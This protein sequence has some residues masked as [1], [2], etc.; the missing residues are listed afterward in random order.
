M[1]E[2]SGLEPDANSVHTVVAEPL[3]RKSNSQCG[4]PMLFWDNAAELPELTE[5]MRERHGDTTL[6]G[7][8]IAINAGQFYPL[9]K[10]SMGHAV[11]CEP[12]VRDYLAA[13]KKEADIGD[14]HGQAA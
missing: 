12:V 9:L 1:A 4:S 13:T 6:Y 5:Q 3:P 10:R 14:R 2:E 8:A 11:T 7:L